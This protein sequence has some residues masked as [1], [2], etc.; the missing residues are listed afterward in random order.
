MGEF[1]Q[2]ATAVFAVGRADASGSRPLGTGFMVSKTRMATAFHVTGGSDAGLFLLIPPA[3]G[4]AHYQD[5][6]IDEFSTVQLQIVATDPVRDLAVLELV[7]AE[8]GH[9]ARIDSLDS[10]KVGE[11]IRTLGFPHADTGRLVMTYREA[12]IGARI[13]IKSAG[14]SSKHAVVNLQGRPGQSGSPVIATD[15]RIVGV[16]VGGYSPQGGGR[17]IVAGID[18]TTLHETTHAVSA[19]YLTGMIN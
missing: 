13:L 7:N 10:V 12:Q 18:P 2:E 6:S 5:T 3:L 11:T 19:E 1:V 14:V 16:V 9:F 4:N 15:G 8:S 17:V